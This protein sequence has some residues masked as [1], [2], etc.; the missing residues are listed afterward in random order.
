MA[1][2]QHNCSTKTLLGVVYGLSIVKEV[3]CFVSSP[4]DVGEE[5]L[6]AERVIQRLKREFFRRIKL[7]PILWEHE[8]LR[9][10]AHFQSQI[11]PPSQTD[12]VICILWS[13]LGTR[14]P[15]EFRRPDG[16]PY[17]SGTE[18][19]FED[20]ADAYRQRGTPDLL[21]YRK[22]SDAT[23]RLT[24]KDAV[25]NALSQ[26]ES[27]DR[28]IDRWF[29]NPAEG[30]RAAFHPF[31][32]A[33]EFE[34][35]LETHL[36][37][38]LNDKYGALPISSA[39]VPTPT[40]GYVE[41]PFRG[42][43]PFDV[44]HANIFFGRTRAIGELKRQLEHQ[45][46]RG[47]AF[48]LVMG[49]SGS[50]KSSLVRAGVI[51]TL[52]QPGVV[53]GVGVWRYG[54]V[55]PADF[56]GGACQSLGAVL[57]QSTALPQLEVLGFGA[58]VASG[59]LRQNPELMLG[60]VRGALMTVATD[61]AREEKLTAV[62]TARLLIVIDQ[63]E[64]IFTGSMQTDTERMAFAAALGALARSGDVWVLATMRS[65]F[66]NRLVELPQLMELKGGEG[67]FDVLPPTFAEL[68]QMIVLPA[69]VAG[70]GFEVDPDTN[71][72]VNQIIHEAATRNPQSLP[73]LEF[74]LDELYKRRQENVLTLAAYRQL[75]GLEG[76]IAG[77]AEEVFAGLPAQVQSALSDLLH[78]LVSLQEGGN[79]AATSRR[80]A[81][82]DLMR[83]P[84]A[85]HLID[86]FVRARLLVVDRD[87]AGQQTIGLAHEALLRHWPR[88]AE[89]IAENQELLRIRSRVTAAADLWAR[90]Q[91]DSDYLLTAAKPLADAETL[92][93]K[94]A[95]LPESLREFVRAST[96]AASQAASRKRVRVIAVAAAFVLMAIGF[97][98]YSFVQWQRA[99][100][101]RQVAVER[102]QYAESQEKLAVERE[103]E[104]ERRR[105]EA[106]EARQ[107]ADAARNRA[108]DAER[109]AVEAKE[110]ETQARLAEQSQ[111]QAKEQALIQEQ[112]ERQ[113]KETALQQAEFNLRFRNV[114]L[115]DRDW[116]INDVAA[117][118]RWLADTP[119]EMRHWEWFHVYHKC[120]GYSGAANLG[121]RVRSIRFAPRGSTMI[122]TADAHR[123]GQPAAGELSVWDWDSGKRLT[124]LEGHQTPPRAAVLL[125]RG[126]RA[127]SASLTEVIQ[128]DVASNTAIKTWPLENVTD[129][130]LSA[131]G[132]YWVSVQRFISE[133]S[134]DRPGCLVTLRE[135]E[136]G[137]EVAEW[138]CW[139]HYGNCIAVSHDGELVAV[140]LD[141][142]QFQVLKRGTEEPWMQSLHEDNP[143][144]RTILALEISP[145]KQHLAIGRF[146]G[147]LAVWSLTKKQ[148]EMSLPEHDA[149][150]VSLTFRANSSGWLLMSAGWDKS[151]RMTNIDSGQVI[152]VLRGHENWIM[153]LGLSASGNTLASG[154]R[155]GELKL[156][157]MGSE[158]RA[159]E[160][161][162]FLG[163]DLQGLGWGST[164]RYWYAVVDRDKGP[165][166]IM[167]DKNNNQ[168]YLSHAVASRFTAGSPDGKKVVTAAPGMD[169]GT[170]LLWELD[171]RKFEFGLELNGHDKPGC[172]GVFLD[173][174]RL[175]TGAEDRSLI[176]W[177]LPAG[178][179]VHSIDLA[180]VPTAMAYL[181]MLQ[182]LAV[183]D[184]NGD[185]QV[186]DTNP[187]Q[188]VARFN[189]EHPV[190]AMAADPTG[191][192]L[193]VGGG[194][195]REPGY[196][197]I[198]DVS[199]EPKM[200]NRLRG[201]TDSISCLAFHPGGQ[202]LA[203]GSDDMIV[204]IWDTVTGMEAMALAGHRHEVT[205]L[206][207]SPSGRQLLSGSRD[208]SV[209]V[210]DGSPVAA[211]GLQ[212]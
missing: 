81:R 192:R 57:T 116:T 198:W 9:A 109:S 4:G 164:E 171:G 100:H 125:E 182:W 174:Q 55:R 53:E 170:L 162:P 104:A 85:E 184:R 29:G 44:K 8:P 169:D 26:K 209:I 21:V 152:R 190:W 123:S 25:L 10:T 141:R 42:L 43:S 173:N 189:V 16:T 66:F 150:V 61:V 161:H 65:D 82:S 106:D 115:A 17:E 58:D 172:C 196:V 212:R 54:I 5:R 122:V 49:M 56:P 92:I 67:Q 120:L 19:E 36:R 28:F 102:R 160:H 41:H 197:A 137:A 15:G 167:V 142:G 118:R 181:P 35:L 132:K 195:L 163:F 90:R 79:A 62:P 77:R 200:L 1:N 23:T 51:P 3:R 147:T 59:L 133:L 64:E 91:Q 191:P 88:A 34:R 76:A 83:S 73:L 69:R 178:E 105:Q 176:V 154:G 60:P 70:V 86:E 38:F 136:T 94:V 159:V 168:R 194:W 33:D 18:W 180:E 11:V 165:E 155:D 95:G 50:G 208:G 72:S 20:A 129:V 99:E 80:T 177:Q 24:S 199:A 22:T 98:A 211:D 148:F 114:V 187:W 7:T 30:F 204:R 2:R 31:K 144:Y 6:I 63:L 27:L 186:W 207:F 110:E 145:D 156:W 126:D 87:E 201:H 121:L 138:V 107:Q 40:T 117:A 131:D 52:T 205:A 45:T 96:K 14:L 193:A 103:Q 37:R 130:A 71:S 202:R 151:I 183:A 84:D 13:R 185:I 206:N 127:V 78:G 89:W 158:Q 93:R 111:R 39:D 157:N 119:V 179:M 135:V 12:I 143:L 68:E 112:L 48:V 32:S 124:I 108:Q 175:V 101:H 46:A 166:L 113:Q 149:A 139:A 146:D 75:G 74:T 153:A 140:S 203:S 188:L 97:S 134:D 47:T 128:W 210:W